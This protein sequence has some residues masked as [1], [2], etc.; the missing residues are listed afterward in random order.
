MI[1]FSDLHLKES[2][3]EICFAVLKWIEEAAKGDVDNGHIIFCGD[4][5]HLRYQ[6]SVRLLNRVAELIDRWTNKLR[7]QVDFVPGNHDQVDVDGHNALEIFE[8]FGGV[9]VWTEPGIERKGNLG[10]VPYRKDLEEQRDSLIAV[11]KE[12]PAKSIVFGHFGVTGSIMNNGKRAI[13]GLENLGESFLGGHQINQRIILGH[14]HRRQ[15]SKAFEYVGSPYQTSFGEAGNTCGCLIGKRTDLKFVEIEVG[16][17]KH[18]ILKWDPTRDENPPPWPGGPHDH[19]RLDIE[20]GHE[21]IVSGKFRTV[22]K[23]SGLEN[24]QVNVVPVQ[25]PREHRFQAQQGE[26]LLD[27]AGRFLR[28]RLVEEK[29]DHW[30]FDQEA[31]ELFSELKGW[32]K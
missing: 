24:A 5:W 14:Y 26:S 20:S 21:A 6:V 1:V 8:A 13:E 19:V 18:H 25:Q 10:F 9:T 23:K 31:D 29:G 12:L 22:L 16:A 27:S 17:P 15:D 2:S 3:E 28:E 30:D 32:A 7:F 4:W 11:R